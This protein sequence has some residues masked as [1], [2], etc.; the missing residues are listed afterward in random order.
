MFYKS[1]WKKFL[2]LERRAF[3]LAELEQI[4]R[5]GRHVPSVLRRLAK[6]SPSAAEDWINFLR[7]IDPAE[8][9]QLIDV[10]ANCG[11]WCQAFLA[12]FPNTKVIAIEPAANTFRALET[13]FSGDPRVR[14]VRA[15]ASERPG[16]A[17]LLLADDST[18]NSFVEYEAE[19]SADRSTV[20]KEREK[21]SLVRIDDVVEID[22]K[23]SRRVLKLDVQGHEIS[24]LKGAAATL[25][26][27][28]VAL[29]ELSFV[30]EYVGVS[31]SFSEATE[32]LRA[33]GLYP[34]VFQEYGTSMTNHRL[35]CDVLY[36][37]AAL[38]KE[39]YDPR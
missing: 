18:L 8:S 17:Q 19:F 1:V 14:A 30:N 20:V 37:R 27:I 15:G 2:S 34:V 36:V 32:L 25:S 6:R 11:E 5:K 38:F 10:G 28:D 4:E 3:L 31:P 21:V 16:S 22:E 13:R 29:C 24:A 26:H 35:E 33:A 23:A 9:V 12:T 7:V 39:F